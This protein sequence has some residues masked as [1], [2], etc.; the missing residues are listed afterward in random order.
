MAARP[1]TAAAGGP[2]G[3]RR[4]VPTAMADR[5]ATLLPYPVMVRARPGQFALRRD[6]PVT[7]GP[8]A[9]QAADAVRQVL[10]A[11]PWPP[12]AGSSTGRGRPGPGQILVDADP[13]LPAEGYRLL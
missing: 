7:A 11:L 12:A 8:A 13:A 6:T 10:A 4:G 5:L 2:A 1:R 9:R 3:R